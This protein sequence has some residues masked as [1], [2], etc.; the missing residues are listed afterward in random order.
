MVKDPLTKAVV[1]AKT[2]NNRH[3]DMVKKPE[4]YSL[5]LKTTACRR[6]KGVNHH[7]PTLHHCIIIK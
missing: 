7:L 2:A 5:S 6:V 1:K 3:L 4:N